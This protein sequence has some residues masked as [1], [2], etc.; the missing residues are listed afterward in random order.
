MGRLRSRVSVLDPDREILWIARRFECNLGAL[1]S[2]WDIISEF[3]VES[4]QV[5]GDG[6]GDD[7]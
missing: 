4:F 3:A 6:T 1:L 7:F 5:M 2:F